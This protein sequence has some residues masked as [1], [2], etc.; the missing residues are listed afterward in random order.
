MFEDEDS[1][2]CLEQI[3]KDLN[4]IE[5]KYSSEEIQKS[6]GIP[7]S[8]NDNLVVLSKVEYLRYK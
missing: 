3:A 5:L 1:L 2:I 7:P 6:F 8:L 4:D